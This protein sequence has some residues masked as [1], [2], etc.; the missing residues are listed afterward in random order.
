MYWTAREVTGLS[1]VCAASL[2]A[3][4]ITRCNISG[5][6][7]AHRSDSLLW[8]LENPESH[9]TLTRVAWKALTE[10][11]CTHVSIDNATLEG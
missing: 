1:H 9:K 2:T 3:L 11:S 10:L 6:S 4:H 8:T 5:V 7:S